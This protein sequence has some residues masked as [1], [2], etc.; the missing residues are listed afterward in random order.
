MPP[1]T[2]ITTPTT[3]CLRGAAG[4]EEAPYWHCCHCCLLPQNRPSSPLLGK[5]EANQGSLPPLRL[6][7]RCTVP[8]H[9]WWRGGVLW[10]QRN[11]IQSIGQKSAIYLRSP[12]PFLLTKC[13][14]GDQREI[15]RVSETSDESRR[16][17]VQHRK[18]KR[19]STSLLRLVAIYSYRQEREG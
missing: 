6:R 16:E 11:I 2:I 5:V 17:M 18:E 1:F 13:P 7:S 15:E 3:P 19:H 12:L 14:Y 10:W 9:P 4:D 8:L